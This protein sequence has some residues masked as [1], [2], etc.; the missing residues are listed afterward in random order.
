MDTALTCLPRS[1]V[2]QL[3]RASGSATRLPPVIDREV[4]FLNEAKRGAAARPIVR[5]AAL[6]VTLA[7]GNAYEG[8]DPAI[9]ADTLTCG[10]VAG[11]LNLSLDALAQLLG[12]LKKLGLVEASDRGLRLTNLH[13]LER[14]ADAAD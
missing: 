14:L 13:E 5:I 2:E 12:E 10:V 4:A 3:E 11:Y 1:A 8:R 6:L 7:R 9:I